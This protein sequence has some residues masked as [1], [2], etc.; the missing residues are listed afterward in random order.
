MCVRFSPVNG[1]FLASA[2]DDRVILIWHQE[3]HSTQNTFTGDKESWRAVKRLVG[4]HESDIVDLAWSAQGEY[5]ASSCLGG[6][7]VIYSG[8]TFGITSIFIVF[9]K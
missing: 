4:A 1:Q 7:V 3:L 2:S 5:L 8:Q 6:R 9:P